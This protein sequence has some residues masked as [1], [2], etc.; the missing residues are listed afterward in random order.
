[1]TRRYTILYAKKTSQQSPRIHKWKSDLHQ[2]AYGLNTNQNQI[3]ELEYYSNM[4]MEGRGTSVK[5]T[6]KRTRKAT[7]SWSDVSSY[8][9]ASNTNKKG[10]G[11]FTMSPMGILYCGSQCSQL[12]T[13]AGD[14]PSS[15]SF[16]YHTCWPVGSKLSTQYQLALSMSYDHSVWCLQQWD[17]S[18][19]QELF[20]LFSLEAWVRIES[21]NHGSLNANLAWKSFR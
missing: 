3:T 15:T 5:T 14:C 2:M 1:M 12:C 4:H 18:S 6:L 11:Y 16:W 13:T 7:C 19:S 8:G 17:L 20:F 10:I 21:S 9:V